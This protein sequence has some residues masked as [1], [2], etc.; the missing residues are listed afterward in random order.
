M[1][2]DPN[3]TSQNKVLVRRVVAAMN[4]RDLGALDELVAEDVVRH[5]PSTPDVVVTNLDQFKAFLIQDF[6][7]VPDS[8]QD[9][10]MMLAEGDLVAVWATYRGTE[11]GPMGPFP[12][13]GKPVEVEFAGILRVANNRIAEIWAVWDNL[14]MLIQLGHLTPPGP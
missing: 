1:S 6:R 5:S 11:D 14:G 3:Q 12:A 2:P 10:R 13:T 4:E 7:G 8:V 9:I